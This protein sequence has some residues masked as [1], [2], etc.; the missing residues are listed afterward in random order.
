MAGK[1]VHQRSLQTLAELFYLGIEVNCFEMFKHQNS[2]ELKFN[3]YTD[4]CCKM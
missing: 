3:K 1:D 4:L 2:D